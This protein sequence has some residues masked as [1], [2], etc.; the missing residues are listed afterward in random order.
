MGNMKGKDATGRHIE[1]IDSVEGRFPAN[2]I[3]DGSEEVMEEFDKAG[4]RKSTKFIAKDTGYGK[5]NTYINYK[6]G[7]SLTDVDGGYTD[8]GS[9][10]RF[11][12]CSKA[13]GKEKNEGLED[14]ESK[15]DTGIGSTYAANQET[16]KI[17]GNPN[18]P[19]KPSKCT[20]PTV[21]PIKL[22]SYLINMITPPNGIVLDPFMG[23]GSTGVAAVKNGFSFIGIE[24][25]PEYMEIAKAR[26]EYKKKK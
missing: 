19:T 2:F 11:F 3:H 18:K 21:K 8:E 20:H 17:G 6:E 9:A 25:E 23:S 4:N 26:I 16:S 14:F 5:S 15:K 22:M 24:K 1:F 7:G 13:S 10:A 12:Y